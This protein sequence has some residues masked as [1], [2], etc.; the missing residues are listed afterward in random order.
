[1]GRRKRGVTTEDRFFEKLEFIPFHGCWEWTGSK[2]PKGY[3]GFFYAGRAIAAH[4]ASWMMARGPI[5]AGL[6]VCHK[7]DNPSCVNP[8][9]LFLG[10]S[11]ENTRD[12]AIK[13]RMGMQRR[14]HCPKGH[15]YVGDN[16][17]VRRIPSFSGR[18]RGCKACAKI[19]GKRLRSTPEWKNARRIRENERRKDPAIRIARRDAQRAYMARKR[20]THVKT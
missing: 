2:G 20:A 18:G 15:P 11:K 19:R 9:H 16:L 13:G 5:P 12:A 1:M 3:G 7:C 6:F 14:T 10:T 17:V 4:R 8:D